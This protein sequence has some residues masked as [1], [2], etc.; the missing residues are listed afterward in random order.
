MILLMARRRRGRNDPL[1]PVNEP[2]WLVVRDR[3]SRPIEYR[4]LWPGADLHAAM[5]AERVR[6][7][8]DGWTVDDIPHYC[9]FCFCERGEERVCISVEC[10]EPGCVPVSQG[11]A[12]PSPQR[13]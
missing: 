9:S 1:T 4:E 13:S 12:R 2:R 11:S 6:R 5:E 10:Y 7:A 3:G 8:A